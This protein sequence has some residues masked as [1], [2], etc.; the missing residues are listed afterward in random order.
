MSF[1]LVMRGVAAS[2]AARAASGGVANL[3]PPV[4]TWTGAVGS[5][6]A[7]TPGTWTGGPTLT[8]TLYRDGVPVTGAEGLTEAAAEAYDAVSADA[9]ATNTVAPAVALTVL[10]GNTPAITPGTWTT[11]DLVWRE[12]PN[13]SDPAGVDSNTINHT[14]T[15]TYD[16]Q[17]NAVDV[18]GQTGKT[19][20][21]TES[22]ALDSNDIWPSLRW[23]E[24]ADGASP[25]ATNVVFYALSQHWRHV[26]DAA[27]ASVSGG[28]VDFIDDTGSHGGINISAALTVRPAFNATDAGF[29]N[30]PSITF[31]GS[32]DQLANADID[33]NA[34]LTS[35]QLFACM[36]IESASAANS[37][38]M[39]LQN[40]TD[41]LRLRQVGVDATAKPR[42]TSVSTAVNSDWTTVPGE[43]V[44]VL[45][46]GRWDGSGP[47]QFVYNG[48]TQEDTDTAVETSINDP[49]NIS[50]GALGG[51]SAFANFTLA[52]A[53]VSC[54]A[55][56]TAAEARTHL[57]AYCQNRFGVP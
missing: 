3:T 8:Y 17:R 14:P 5:S 28:V 27:N 48:S 35:G 7:I 44:E 25:T 32:N 53:V 55:P 11:P 52:L 36:R 22:R 12:I 19:E 57:L 37:V 16:L 49:Q 4:V 10:I 13:G 21:Q 43:G 23:R 24:R 20:A 39:S 51:G 38:W 54:N 31:D 9:A 47:S 46:G 40:G 26:Y 2:A 18:G 15:L 1:P 41:S 6:P 45:A 56:A 42:F 29:N 34:A 30:Q 33:L 50:I